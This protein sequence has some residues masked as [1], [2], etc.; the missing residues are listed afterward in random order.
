[1][2]E[3]KTDIKINNSLTLIGDSNRPLSILDRRIRQI[4]KEIEDLSNTISQT[5]LTDT[6]YSIQQQQNTHLF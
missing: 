6:E 2:Q 1:M 5:N 3:T 4:N